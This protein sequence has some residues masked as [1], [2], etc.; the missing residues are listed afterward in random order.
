[1]RNRNKKPTHFFSDSNATI[2][3]EVI[4]LERAKSRLLRVI[5]EKQDLEEEHSE[6]YW[7]PENI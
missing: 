7:F 3:A 4:S 1:M 6:Q 2:N 5:S